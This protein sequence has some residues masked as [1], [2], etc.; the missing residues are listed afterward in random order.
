[1]GFLLARWSELARIAIQ[2]DNQY[3]HGKVAI[4]SKPYSSILLW[5]DPE[6]VGDSVGRYDIRERH[7]VES[8]YQPGTWWWFCNR[9][10]RS[11]PEDWMVR[12]RRS[13]FAK[14]QL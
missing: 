9:V 6:A 14:H 3:D 11:K 8:T 5:P 4:W 12:R 13:L 2:K 1:M 10:I 7:G